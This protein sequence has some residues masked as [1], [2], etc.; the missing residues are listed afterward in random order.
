MKNSFTLYAGLEWQIRQ[1]QHEQSTLNKTSNQ[2]ICN[3]YTASS[4]FLDRGKG[5]SFSTWVHF[6]Q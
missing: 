1:F 2:L 6:K 5:A 4:P 3:S